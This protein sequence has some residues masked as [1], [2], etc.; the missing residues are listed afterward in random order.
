MTNSFKKG[1]FVIVGMAV[2][3]G[4]FFLSKSSIVQATK[5]EG[6]QFDDWQVSCT[7]K[8]E[9]SDAPQIC[10]LT[11][12]V[13]IGEEDKQQL[14]AVYQIGYFGE[15]KDLKMIQILP[16]GISVEAGTSIVSSKNMVALGRYTT[17]TQAGCQAIANISEEELKKILATSENSVAFMNVEGKLINIPL[18]NKG[19]EKGLAFLRK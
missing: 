4:A 16:L 9:N 18:S 14:L 2:I 10:F 6:K 1:I 19:L 11:Q 15:N 13:M 3:V 7:P 5:K 8:D 17:C 12:Q